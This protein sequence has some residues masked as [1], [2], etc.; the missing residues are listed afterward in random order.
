MRIGAL[1]RNRAARRECD[2]RFWPRLE[3]VGSFVLSELQRIL[4]VSQNRLEI[5]EQGSERENFRNADW[6]KVLD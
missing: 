5:A 3:N 2:V 6:L 4:F 1:T